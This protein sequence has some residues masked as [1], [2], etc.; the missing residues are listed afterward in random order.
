MCNRRCI[1]G[2][3]SVY[4]FPLR[5]AR[6]SCLQLTT[7]KRQN[8]AATLTILFHPALVHRY[9]A[10]E[11]HEDLRPGRDE[12]PHLPIP[13]RPQEYVL[14]VVDLLLHC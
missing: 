7:C 6:F 14:C 9:S 5:A 8:A 4:E 1:V 10:F 12:N 11:H 13:D 3:I 2:T